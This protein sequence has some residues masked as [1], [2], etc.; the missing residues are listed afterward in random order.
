MV[1]GFLSPLPIAVPFDPAEAEGIIGMVD[2][3]AVTAR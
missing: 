1:G 2:A 3:L